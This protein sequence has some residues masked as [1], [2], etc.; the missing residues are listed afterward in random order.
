MTVLRQIERR[1][2]T[3]TQL[4]DLSDVGRQDLARWLNGRRSIRVSQ[5]A[6]VMAVLRI[7]VVAEADNGQAARR[8]Q[9]R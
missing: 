9:G 8:M 4:A 5:A 7:F 1:K 6:K 2:M 3:I